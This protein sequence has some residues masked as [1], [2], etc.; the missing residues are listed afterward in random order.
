MLMIRPLLQTPIARARVAL[1]HHQPHSFLCRA[2]LAGPVKSCR[3]SVVRS[4]SGQSGP[5][6]PGNDAP[7]PIDDATENASEEEEREAKKAAWKST[8]WKMFESA[9]TTGAS[10]FILACVGIGYTKYYKW[11]VIEKMEN[12]FREGDPVLELA[13][14]GK[15]IPREPTRLEVT[16]GVHDDDDKN[17]DRWIP[18]DEQE[19]I[20][21]IVWGETKGRYHL[22]L[23]EK[24]TGKTSMLIDAMDKINGEG[25]SMM[26]AHADLEVFRI[27]LGRCL[28]FE[29]HEDNI[30]S[31]FSIRGPRDAGAILDIERAFNKLEKVALK[32]RASIGRPLI[33]II[34]SAHLIRD[35]EDGR[36]LLE[37][38]QQRAEQWAAS[39]LATIIINSDK[40][41]VFERLKQYATR[42]EVHQIKD[43]TKDR[44][45]QALRNYRMKYHGEV[46]K[47]SVLEEVYDKIGGRLTFL[48]R[49]A[50][51]E[52]ML[53]KCDHICEMEKIWFLNNCAILGEE[54]DDD[55]MDQQ[56]YASTAMVLANALYKRFQ[57]MDVTYNDQVGHILPAFPLHRARFIM[58]RSDFIRKH[59]D[60]SIFSIDSHAMVR[61]DSVPMQRAFN[62]ICAEPGFEEFLEATLDRISAIE[63]LGRTKE[64]T[65]KDLWEG[66]KY[67]VTTRDAK[68]VV[69]GGL[70]VETVE[71]KKGDDDEK[72]EDD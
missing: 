65:F 47:T 16:K 32:R 44:A 10:I 27:R 20:D 54:M 49:V 7:N 60:L 62:E 15:E 50:K 64:L 58:T 11:N 19:K 53:A 69:S 30:G 12:A 34:N 36:D 59:H 26:E 33:L 40:Y 35:D 13:A 28:D 67:R 25:C 21:K 1:Q 42:M 24:G 52:D 38:I 29:F 46:T 71:G 6:T 14:T 4:L 68:G 3:P 41:W 43:L 51:S 63:S 37:L 57:E 2:Q 8:A 23:G 56:K 55:V 70:E 48:N 17:Y 22:L 61:A 66:G 45:M 31:L 18:R 72:K 5:P 39:N 9:A